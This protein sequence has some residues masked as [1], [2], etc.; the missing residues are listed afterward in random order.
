MNNKKNIIEQFLKL[1]KEGENIKSLCTQFGICKSTAYNWIREY[2]PFP[3]DE[4]NG[5]GLQAGSFTLFLYNK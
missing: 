4:A 2:T 3:F 1:H 5:F